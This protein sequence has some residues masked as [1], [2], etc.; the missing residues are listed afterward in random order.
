MYR[1]LS[2]LRGEHN[3]GQLHQT[4]DRN[5]IRRQFSRGA[6][7]GVGEWN[8]ERENYKLGSQAKIS[9]KKE[10]RRSYKQTNTGRKGS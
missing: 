3:L 8:Y 10:K 9:T 7:R 6:R 5:W 2:I 1:Q 4:W